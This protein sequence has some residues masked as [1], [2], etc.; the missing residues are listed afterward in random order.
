MRGRTFE[1]ALTWSD[2]KAL[3]PRAHF[4]AS[5][6]PAALTV[7]G[8]VLDDAGVYRCRADFS[9]SATRNSRVN[10]TVIGRS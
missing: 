3:G 6:R 1:E 7:D 8:V 4:A 2:S 9:N 5:T 10:L